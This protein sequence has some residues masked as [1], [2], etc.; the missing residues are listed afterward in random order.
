[1]NPESLIGFYRIESGEDAN[2]SQRRCHPALATGRHHTKE[3]NMT[4]MDLELIDAALHAPSGLDGLAA[5]MAD[6]A[7]REPANDRH[8]HPSNP[9]APYAIHAVQYWR[10]QRNARVNALAGK[11]EQVTRLRVAARAR[12]RP[13]RR[14]G[15]SP[16]SAPNHGCQ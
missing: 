13:A 15:T 12:L 9:A 8:A 11:W 5:D 6:L 2:R 7:G 14:I 3:H 4:T 1:M 10:Q 16:A